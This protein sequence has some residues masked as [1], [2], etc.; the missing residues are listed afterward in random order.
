MLMRR[1]W[2]F[3]CLAVA[4]ACVSGCGG[5]G[6][7]S[8]FPK[9]GGPSANTLSPQSGSMQVVQ[10]ARTNASATSSITITLSSQPLAGDILVAQFSYDGTE[11]FANTPVG[12]HWITHEESTSEVGEAEYWHL[13][14][15]GESDSYTFGVYNGG[16]ADIALTVEEISGANSSNPIANYTS[17]S[18]STGYSMTTLTLSAS[19]DLPIGLFTQFDNGREPSG[20]GGSWT[21]A[22]PINFGGAY[23]VS[24]EFQVGPLSSGSISDTESWSGGDNSQQVATLLLIAAGSGVSNASASGATH[25]HQALYY[26]G[27]NLNLGVPVSWLTQHADFAEV[28][29]GSQ[30][31][32]FLSAGGKYAAIYTDPNLIPYC[33]TSAPYADCT[34][35]MGNVAESG[36]LHSSSGVRLHTGTGQDRTNPASGAMQTEFYDYTASIVSGSSANAIL[37]DDAQPTYS[38]SYFEY[39]YGATAEEIDSQSNPQSYWLAGMEAL[40]RSSVEPII[41]NGGEND[42]YD[43]AYIQSSNILGRMTEG[44]FVTGAWRVNDTE[45]NPQDNW[46]SD[47]DKMIFGTSVGKYSIC[48]NSDLN[49][50]PDPIGDRLYALSSWWLTY[51]PNYS[52]AFPNFTAPDNAGGYASENFAEYDIVPTGPLSTA[53]N[54]DITTLQSSTG[55]YV[56]EFSACYQGGQA[57][58]PCAAVVNPHYGRTVSMPPL[59]QQYSHSLVLTNA[60]EYNGGTASFTGSIPTSLGQMTGV[61]LH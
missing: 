40:A 5:G 29:Y 2:I 15:S 18:A 7:A 28:A 20:F 38:T 49:G 48:M 14:A 8:A 31:T 46:M 13:V 50:N 36:F 19:N 58:G 52:V 24:Q 43:Q 53:S 17:N 4:A 6:G 27:G 9:P 54:D 39:K 45:G 60:S 25:V 56:R 21:G 47:A 23:M 11:H 34:G 30:A 1:V 44:C 51:D 57:I 22:F 16:S 3:L 12:W 32:S 35:P 41:Y 10:A 42:S 26:G 55:A 37:M 59:Q 61:I 33:S